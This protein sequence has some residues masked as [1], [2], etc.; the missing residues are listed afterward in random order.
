[1]EA[2]EAYRRRHQSTGGN[3]ILERRGE[4]VCGIQ[5]KTSNG[6]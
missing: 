4:L 6:I 5:K 1:M 2:L 3:V